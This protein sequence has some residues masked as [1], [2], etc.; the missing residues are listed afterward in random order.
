MKSGETLR[1]YPLFRDMNDAALDTVVSKLRTVTVEPGGYLCRQGEP[2]NSL[3]LVE[4]GLLEVWLESG[5]RTSL[6]KR[7]RRGDVV[8]EMA[9]LTGE[10]RSAHVIA[11]VSSTVLELD[12]QTFATMVTAHPQILRNIALILIHR[13]QESAD[14]RI[15]RERGEAVALVVGQE[16][17]SII[18][19]VMQT[20]EAARLKTPQILDLTGR[21]APGKNRISKTTV[22]GVLE[23]LDSHL[24]R[25]ERVLVPV[26]DRQKDLPALLRHMDRV[27]VAGDEAVM[28]Q[29][30]WR[31]LSGLAADVFLIGSGDVSL[32]DIETTHVIRTTPLE[33]LPAD[34]AWLGRHLVRAKLGLALGAGGAKGFA[35]VGAYRI[36]EQAGYRF[37]YI[38]GSSIGSILGSCI[39][40]GMSG[41]ELASTARWLLSK[42]V[43]GGYFRL[44]STDESEDAHTRFYVALSELCRNRTFAEL[45]SALAV[46][47]ADLNA[48]APYVFKSGRLENALH[49]ALSIPGLAPPYE[50]E[51][52]RLVDGV[53]ISPVPTAELKHLGADITVS[54]NL[55]NRNEIGHWPGGEQ[56]PE[57]AKKRSKTLDPVVET[58]IMLQLDTSVR[59]AAEADVVISPAFAPSSWRD[60]HL[61]TQF[62]DAGRR[63]AEAA[64]PSLQALIPPT[65]SS[66]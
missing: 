11:A 49:A 12:A 47:T 27:I 64:L 18:P 46:M 33:P 29:F 52:R 32:D 2:G 48:K 25:S 17:L 31:A 51:A 57:I 14:V 5:S 30:D 44:V 43:C 37:D 6:I 24:H 38:A 56:V 26:D 16:Y 59:N 28:A 3:F 66:V 39:A 23:D 50:Y 40:M 22:A 4:N 60:V 58:L 20:A 10:P 36:L 55:M 9:L 13:E 53:T 45:K 1:Q 61:F 54:V 19:G 35:H 65:M 41:T 15:R 21:L 62:E 42:E 8:G 7:M 34:L 63:A